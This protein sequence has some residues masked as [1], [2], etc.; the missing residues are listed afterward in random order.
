[1]DNHELKIWIL[2]ILCLISSIL[3]TYHGL[4]FII[5]EFIMDDETQM[6]EHVERRICTTNT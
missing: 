6:I 4:R 5:R 1:M 2:L 3:L